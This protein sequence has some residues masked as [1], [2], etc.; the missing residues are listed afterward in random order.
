MTL[1]RLYR[2][3]AET[4]HYGLQFGSSRAITTTSI[5]SYVVADQGRCIEARRSTTGFII[6][7]KDASIMQKYVR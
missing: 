7:I 5:R 4:L 2:Y 3:L 1:K 6:V